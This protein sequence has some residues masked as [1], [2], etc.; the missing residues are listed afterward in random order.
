MRPSVWVFDLDG[1][2]LDTAELSRQAYAAVGITMP[3][4]AWGTS[5]KEWLP[6]LLG[7]NINAAAAIH[8]SKTMIY[9]RELIRCDLQGMELPALEVARE[10]FA[11]NPT[12]VKIL[13]ASSALSC[14]RILNRLGFDTIEYHTELHFIARQQHLRSWAVHANVTYVD[15]NNDTINR[16]AS[17]PSESIKLVHYTDQSADALRA[18]MGTLT[19]T[20]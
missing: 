10:L 12:R 4:H 20:Q 14:R 15:D 18:E 7:G 9:L 17:K 8:A 19:W 5:W 2:L 11:D 13:T 16:L 3:D 1:T 6:D